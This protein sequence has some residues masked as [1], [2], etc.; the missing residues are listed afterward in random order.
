MM[1]FGVV[2]KAIDVV[3]GGGVYMLC[4]EVRILAMT[5]GMR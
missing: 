3:A 1:A 5:L 4:I 2:M